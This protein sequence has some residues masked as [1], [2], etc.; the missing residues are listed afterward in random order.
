[1]ACCAN[2][3]ENIL[4]TQDQENKDSEDSIQHPFVEVDLELSMFNKTNK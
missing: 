4:T 3:E 1:M 2:P